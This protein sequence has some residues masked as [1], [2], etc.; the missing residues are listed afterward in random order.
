[1]KHCP[2]GVYLLC[3][4]HL[5]IGISAFAGGGSLMWAPDGSLLGMNEGWLLHTPFS[6]YFIPGLFLFL[7]IG[8]LPMLVFF[9]L[10]FQPDW[11]FYELLNIYKQRHGAWA[12]SLFSGIIIITWII[13][14]QAI[15]SYFWLQPLIAAIGLLIIII[16][17]MPAV[18]RYYTKK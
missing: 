16:T 3:F 11:K 18:I 7:F 12:Y 1:M 8:I 2:A 10:I 15:A 6:N 13:I 14:Q 5:V 9:G 17:L 4:L